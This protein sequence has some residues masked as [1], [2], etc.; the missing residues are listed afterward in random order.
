MNLAL[1]IRDQGRFPMRCDQM[2]ALV[3]TIGRRFGWP[4]GAGAKMLKA[5]IEASLIKC[6]VRAGDDG[7]AIV[8]AERALCAGYAPW[9]AGHFSY[10]SRLAVDVSRRG[11]TGSS[12]PSMRPCATG[13]RREF[14]LCKIIRSNIVLRSFRDLRGPLG[15]PSH[16]HSTICRRAASYRGAST[17][18]HPRGTA[19]A[20][21]CVDRIPDGPAHPA[22]RLSAARGD[23]GPDPCPFGGRG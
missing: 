12:G 5:S 23:A 19:Q 17:W 7:Q 10:Q 13:Q 6:S 9:Q 18:L 16:R 22:R 14:V 3:D 20:S 15:R 4:A 8:H 2:A 21:R 1:A 11:S